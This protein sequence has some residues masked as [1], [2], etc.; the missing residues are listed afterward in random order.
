MS[1]FQRYPCESSHSSG[2]VSVKAALS[3][4]SVCVFFSAVL[5]LSVTEAQEEQW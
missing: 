2:L 1:S 4:G 5:R 3:P